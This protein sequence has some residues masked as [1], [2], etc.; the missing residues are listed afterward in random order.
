MHL[1]FKQTLNLMDTEL[2]RIKMALERLPEDR[3]WKKMR[4]S[5]N[6][7][8]NLCLH[9]AGHEYQ[10]MISGI[11]QNPFIRERSA[12]FLADGE[13]SSGELLEKLTGIREQTRGILS[14][15][16]ADDLEREVFIEYPPDSGIESYSRTIIELVY[17]TTAHY[18]YHTGQIVYMTRI[19][20]DGDDR[21]LKWNH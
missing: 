7:V 15:L 6:S 16:T 13:Y 1:F 8:G 11:G 17:H 14:S 5:T 21:L 19:L 4:G 12:E 18:S 3:V 20:Q 9:L 10:N 2:A